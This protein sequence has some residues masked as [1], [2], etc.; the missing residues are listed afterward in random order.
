ITLRWGVGMWRFR[1]DANDN[2]IASKELGHTRPV[3]LGDGSAVKRRFAPLPR[4]LM[5][6]HAFVNRVVGT[7]CSSGTGVAIAGVA[8]CLAFSLGGCA[9]WDKRRGIDPSISPAALKL[10]P[11]NQMRIL[12]ALANDASIS[13]G[14]PGSWYE[15]SQAGFNFVDDECRA[16][17]NAIFFLNRDKDQLKSGLSAVGATTAAILGVTGASSK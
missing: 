10:S 11:S 8:L 1:R 2:A 12:A 4:S 14:A 13:L 7:S 16:Y 15:V 6:A 5:A 17:F 9:D 3:N